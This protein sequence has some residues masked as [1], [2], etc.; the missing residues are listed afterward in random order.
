MARKNSMKQIHIITDDI[1]EELSSLVVALEVLIPA[2]TRIKTPAQAHLIAGGIQFIRA[3][4]FDIESQTLPD[5]SDH[6]TQND[7]F[8]F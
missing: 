6:L 7:D 1:T 5:L 2:I 8:P 4:L 3:R